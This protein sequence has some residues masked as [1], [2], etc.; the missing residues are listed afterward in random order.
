MATSE[1]NTERRVKTH[2]KCVGTDDMVFE[3]KEEPEIV[4]LKE[5]NN[6]RDRMDKKISAHKE[7]KKRTWSQARP[8][9]QERLYEEWTFKRA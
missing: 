6:V 3:P 9:R 4:I 2:R 1:A 5:I 8:S 7:A